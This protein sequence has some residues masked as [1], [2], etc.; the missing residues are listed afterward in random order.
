M[1]AIHLFL[2]PGQLLSTQSWWGISDGGNARVNGCRRSFFA[3][4]NKRTK[5]RLLIRH[6]SASFFFAMDLGIWQDL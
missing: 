6:L 3:G 2:A 5:C 4:L 1:Q